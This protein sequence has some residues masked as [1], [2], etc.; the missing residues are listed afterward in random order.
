MTGRWSRSI[1]QGVTWHGSSVGVDP[2]FGGVIHL[3]VS[4]S[5]WGMPAAMAIHVGAIRKSHVGPVWVGHPNIEWQLSRGDGVWV[6]HPLSCSSVPR[7][8]AVIVAGV[9]WW[10]NIWKGQVWL[11]L[12]AGITLDEGG[13]TGGVD[14]MGLVIVV[15]ASK[16]G[17]I[18]RVCE[19]LVSVTLLV[20]TSRCG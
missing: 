5:A 4:G 11:G 9:G 12:K 6:G 1:G 7:V 3:W 18:G 20:W 10:W 17:G 8:E 13:K 14:L 2:N 16:L 15:P 19:S